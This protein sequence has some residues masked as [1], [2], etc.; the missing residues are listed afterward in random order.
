MPE[1]LCAAPAAGTVTE[2]QRGLLLAAVVDDFSPQA[3]SDVLSTA[4]LFFAPGIQIFAHFT[5]NPNAS[6]SIA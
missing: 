2:R 3:R 1:R 5:V 4:M 6:K